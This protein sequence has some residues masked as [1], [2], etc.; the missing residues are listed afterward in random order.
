MA[1]YAQEEPAGATNKLP[2]L[3]V[4][5]ICDYVDSHNNDVWKKDM[6]LR[7]L[8]SMQSNFSKTIAPEE[9][10]RMNISIDI[11]NLQQPVEYLVYEVSQ[12]IIFQLDLPSKKRN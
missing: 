2:C 9:V 5:G 3:H 7:L 10:W 8:Q 4:R 11:N 12:G 6:L 1:F